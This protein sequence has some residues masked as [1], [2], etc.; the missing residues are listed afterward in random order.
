M[1]KQSTPSFRFPGRASPSSNNPQP[2]GEIFNKT[3]KFTFSHS[4]FRLLVPGSAIPPDTSLL[5]ARDATVTSYNSSLRSPHHCHPSSPTPILR[6]NSNLY[7]YTAGHS[8]HSQLLKYKPHPQL[9]KPKAVVVFTMSWFTSNNALDE[10]VEKATS[11]S[12]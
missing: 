9:P 10:Q 3:F 2:K 4:F 11:S 5:S 6:L 7:E 1:A 12:L 8:P